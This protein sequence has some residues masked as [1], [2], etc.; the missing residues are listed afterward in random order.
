MYSL[1]PSTHHPPDPEQIPPKRRCLLQGLH[2][3]PV[4]LIPDFIVEKILNEIPSIYDCPDKMIWMPNQNGN[5]TVKSAWLVTRQ[6]NVFNPV[7]GYIWHDLIPIKIFIFMWKVLNNK[8]P[9]DENI[10]K[11]CISLVSKCDCCTNFP[12]VETVEHVLVEGSIACQVWFD[13]TQLTRG[14]IIGE[15]IDQIRVQFQC[16]VKTLHM[17]LRDS[18]VSKLFCIP[19]RAS[20]KG[21]VSI[22]YWNPPPH[23]VTIIN[24]DGSALNNP[25]DSGG[26]GVI[27]RSSGIFVAAFSNFYGS[28]SITFAEMMAIHEGINLAA[29]LGLSNLL[30]ESDSL[31]V[32][33]I[34]SESM[35]RPWNLIYLKSY[36][37]KLWISWGSQLFVLENRLP[38]VFLLGVVC[39]LIEEKM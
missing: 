4:Q 15:I 1:A 7:Y 30:V 34:L 24:C 25:R 20:S 23:D 11:K 9:V 28:N 13:Q 2:P 6:S 38:V 35:S 36:S 29:S 31:I 32:I 37:Q 22:L 33:N 5:F 27:R 12:H 8:L 18:N 17:E 21:K 19:M 26:G 10:K 16:K 3:P 14:Q 39:K